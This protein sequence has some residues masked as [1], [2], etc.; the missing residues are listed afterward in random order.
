MRTRSARGP[1][2]AITA[3]HPTTLHACAQL[4]EHDFRA[5]LIPCLR[6]TV[7]AEAEEGQEEEADSLL[8]ASW[9][10]G[11]D[12]C[13]E[14]SGLSDKIKTNDLQEILDALLPDIKPQPLIRWVDDETA[15]Y[16][17]P[18]VTT[19]AVCHTYGRGVWG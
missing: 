10:G 9:T 2:A 4:M 1:H 11:F 8:V 16:V 3:A 15:L 5:S 14:I 18:N 17:C 13:V 12:H 19:G 7:H 6:P